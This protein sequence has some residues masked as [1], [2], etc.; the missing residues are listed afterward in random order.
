M[1]EAPGGGSRSEIEQRLIQR[2]LEDDSFRKALLADPKAAIE[3]EVGTELSQS[4][5]HC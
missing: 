3:Q 1:C 2:N 5:T 4:P